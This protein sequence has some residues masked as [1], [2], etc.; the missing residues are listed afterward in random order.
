MTQTIG[1]ARD[2]YILFAILAL[3]ILLASLQGALPPVFSYSAGAIGLAAVHERLRRWF[4]PASALFTVL[5]IFGATSL[6][7]S[8]T[9]DAA[10][11]EPAA[12]AIAAVALAAACREPWRTPRVVAG[13]VVAVAAPSLL[14]AVLATPVEAH[15]V[16]LDSGPMGLLFSSTH[17]LF[18][19]TPI[20]YLAF[21]GAMAL[22]F[23]DRRAAAL[24][25]ATFLAMLIAVVAF[26]TAST[27]PA[28]HRLT[29]A[30]AV[31]APGL[32]YAIDRAMAR[33][34]LA[35][36]P[37]VLGV[38]VWNYWL[39][40]QYT[41]GT[42]PKDEPVSFSGMVRQQMAVETRSP[43]VYPFALPA[44]AWFAWREGIPVERFEQL[45]FEPRLAS[46]D[47][48]MDKH[49]DRFLLE[50]WEPGGEDAGPR[51]IRDA[52]AGVTLPFE[53]PAGRAVVVTVNARTRLEE[54][55][56]SATLALEANGQE[57][58][59]FVV[60]P[61][62]PADFS[63]EVPADAVGRVWRAGY[64][65]LTF[66]SDGVQRIDPTDTRPPGPLGRRLK[67]RPW[68]V[69]I[70]RVRITPAP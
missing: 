33:P 52:R 43:Y 44:N 11:L 63:I 67:D 38:A 58:G 7:W 13:A 45:A 59:R 31:L 47:Q 46:I 54:P 15:A 40:I 49:A 26:P 53:P 36:V 4:S 41:V 66:V 22:A 62:A 48:P 57:I 65:R 20:V 60:P 5:L 32:A 16:A 27:G 70:Y 61:T 2:R 29:A 42:L 8:M 64:N 50:G 21:A 55:A 9:R 6:F 14:R 30:L 25:V 1:P 35:I 28:A 24:A 56:V 37:L 51:W 68:P 10:P 3:G 12:F 19:L 17:G 69:A 23:R 34:W 39:M 18:T